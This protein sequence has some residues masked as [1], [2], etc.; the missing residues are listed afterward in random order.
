MTL[1]SIIPLASTPQRES[2]ASIMYFSRAKYLQFKRK[3]TLLCALCV[4]LFFYFRVH[5]GK[6]ICSSPS[7]YLL[8]LSIALTGGPLG[9]RLAAYFCAPTNQHADDDTGWDLFY[10]LG[11]NGPWI[12]KVE[13]V[14]HGTL[15]PPTGCDV[16]QVHMVIPFPISARVPTILVST[17]RPYCSIANA[18]N[19]QLSRHAER[20]PTQNAGARGFCQSFEAVRCSADSKLKVTS[21]SS[22]ASRILHSHFSV[23][24]SLL[25]PGPTLQIPRHLNSKS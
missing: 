10:H 12:P 17:T 6:K 9:E 22:N 19:W 7:L 18:N 5:I 13:G 3:L 8:P 11:G 1:P 2:S 21:S 25:I 20:Y 4:S 24:W 15:A 16:D 23:P 14:I